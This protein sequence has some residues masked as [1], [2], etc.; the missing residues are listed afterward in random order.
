MVE[1]RPGRIDFPSRTG[2]GPQQDDQTQSFATPVISFA[3]ILTGYELRY[4]SSDHN[5]KIGTVNV[6]GALVDP[7]TINVTCT[8]GLRDKSSDWD[9]SY[10][11][12]V[13]YTVVAETQ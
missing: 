1:F 9:D 7:T 5:F 8:L 13:A 12:F 6:E 4:D 3:V 11:G 10:S 2:F